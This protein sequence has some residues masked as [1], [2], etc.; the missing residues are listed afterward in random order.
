MA[1]LASELVSAV[2]GKL[3]LDAAGAADIARFQIYES[4]SEAQLHLMNI[5]PIKYLSEGIKTTL[6]NLITN[7]AEYQWPT[8]DF[9]F[10]RYVSLWV[11][12][13]NAIVMTGGTVNPGKRVVEYD[14]DV[15]HLP[16]NQVATTNYP[17][18]DL[19][20]EV[21]YM[22]YPVP[23]VGVTDGGRLRYI[24]KPKDISASQDSLLNPGLK[25]LLIFKATPLSALVDQ[26]RPDLA[27]VYEGFYDKEL[28]QFL[29]KEE[30]DK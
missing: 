29:P 7:E 13:A 2:I 25:N 16:I 12:F 6:F 8:L 28:A 14:A 11:D 19:N 23:S 10:L 9:P 5:L 17:F 26:Y 20:V 22:I 24:Y 1:I 21:G 30:I 18:V 4:L 3:E 27:K 15:H